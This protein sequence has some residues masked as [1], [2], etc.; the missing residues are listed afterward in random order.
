MEN[1]DNDFFDL[2]VDGE[3]EGFY[4]LDELPLMIDGVVIDGY[5]LIEVCLNDNEDCCAVLE[6]EAPDCSAEG[7]CAFDDLFVETYEC[8]EEGNFLIDFTFEVVNPDAGSFNVHINGDYYGNYAYG[9]SFYTIGPFDGDCE[10]EYLISLYDELNDGCTISSSFGPVCCEEEGVCEI[11]G[12]EAYDFEC[13]SEDTYSLYISFGVENGENDF[14]DLFVDGEFEGFYSLEDL[15][16]MIDGVLIDGNTVVEVCIN[17]N[18]D[19]CSIIEFEPPD[20]SAEGDCL[21]T[22]LYI[23][24]YGCDDDDNFLIDFEFTIDNPEA[25]SFNVFVNGVYL[26]NLAYGE[27]Y[28]TVGPFEGDCE[29]EYTLYVED[30]LDNDCNIESLFGPVCCGEEDCEIS[31]LAIFDI[32]CD[33]DGLGYSFYV[34]FEV[35]N[36]GND[37]FEVWIDGVYLDF[38]LLEELPLHIED[39]LVGE[40]VVITVCINDMEDCCQEMEVESPECEEIVEDCEFTNLEIEIGACNDDGLF[41]VDFWFDISDPISDSFVVYLNGDTIGSFVYGEDYYTIHD[42]VGDCSTEYLLYI[43]DPS[44]ECAIEDI[45]GQVCCDEPLFSIA[46]FDNTIYV[47]DAP[48]DFSFKVFQAS[49]RYVAKYFVPGSGEYPIDQFDAS[50]YILSYEYEGKLQHK[51]IVKH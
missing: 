24:T 45:F 42:I 19:C 28:Y 16:L 34:D 13:E 36:P 14:F 51:K 29:T 22:E 40:D 11:Y 2:F 30:E 50:I 7:D 47:S 8:D 1:G 32:V 12:L 10:S 35:E 17:D 43:E 33:E 39:M 20:C 21:F 5:T 9:E 38:Y 4:S 26:D 44:L 41:Y 3:F 25:G 15:P 6:V 49:G 23:E 48:E 37:Y 46:Y 18:E 31:E 27:D